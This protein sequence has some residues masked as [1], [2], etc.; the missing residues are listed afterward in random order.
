MTKRTV[1][2]KLIE[3]DGTVCGIC[4]GS[5]IEELAQLWRYYNHP[6]NTRGRQKRKTINVNIDHKTPKRFLPM[7]GLQVLSNLQLS[8]KTCNNEK[9]GQ[10][11]Y[12]PDGIK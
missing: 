5:L 3:R 2:E 6:P 1:I 9:G 8:H 12:V 7:K 11:Y 4:R 10:R